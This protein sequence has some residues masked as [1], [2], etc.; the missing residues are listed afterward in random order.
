MVHLFLI[1][2]YEPVSMEIKCVDSIKSN[3]NTL[4][5]NVS[6]QRELHIICS[7]SNLMMIFDL[8]CYGKAWFPCMLNKSVIAHM[9]DKM[10]P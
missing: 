10:I 8:S 3:Y 5:L 6:S 7:R 9:I 4:S 1:L 2:E